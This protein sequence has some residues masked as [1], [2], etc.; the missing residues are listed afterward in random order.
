[1]A[2]CLACLPGCGGAALP[3][4]QGVSAEGWRVLRDLDG[5][6]FGD[7]AEERW[8][9]RVEGDLDA[10]YRV[11]LKGPPRATGVGTVARSWIEDPVP[12]R[13]DGDVA[14]LYRR[15][16]TRPHPSLRGEL[17]ER[18]RRWLDERSMR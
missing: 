7:G 12:V 3:R 16:H 11:V 5:V 2:T 6:E 10:G 14:D 8:E 4:S 9:I 1:M 13:T 18:Y 17:S 15:V